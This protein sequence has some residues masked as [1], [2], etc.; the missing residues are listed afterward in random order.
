MTRLAIQKNPLPYVRSL[1]R[2]RPASIELV[3]IHCTELPD[4]ATAREFGERILYVDSAT[5]NSGHYYI[6]RSGRI[7][8]WVPP[9]RVAHHVRGY[10][11]RSIGIELVN[12][13]RYPHWFDSR[14]Q[15]MTEPYPEEQLDSLRRLLNQLTQTLPALRWISGHAT[16]D[17]DELAASDNPE[18]QVKRKQDPGPLFPWAALL[19]GLALDYLE[20]QSLLRFKTD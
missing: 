20:G 3:V 18:L 9:E 7:E 1:A 8:E 15:Q 5:G 4:L 11:A 16:L 17:S 12:R 14:F 13:G 6:E 19:Q 10:N 2:R